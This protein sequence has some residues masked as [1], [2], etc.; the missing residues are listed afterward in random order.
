MWMDQA[1]NTT[2]AW[3]DPRVRVRFDTDVMLER[4][5]KRLKIRDAQRAMR[6]RKEAE[7][8]RRRVVAA[9][10]ELRVG[11]VDID[12]EVGEDV[13]EDDCKRVQSQ[14]TPLVFPGYGGPHHNGQW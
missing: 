1:K 9:G 2:D 10:G 8:R 14:V 5:A 6:R 12:Q 13:K 11:A 4:E 3:T 7:E